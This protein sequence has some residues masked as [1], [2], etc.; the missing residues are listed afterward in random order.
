MTIAI[1]LVPA[2]PKVH[3]EALN[4]FIERHA[5]LC[6]FVPLEVVLE[7]RWSKPMPVDHGSSYR[8]VPF[9]RDSLSAQRFGLTRG[10]PSSMAPSG[11]VRC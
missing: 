4:S 11:P 6:E 8:A 2:N 3:E 5:M 9:S 7:I 10:A 1:L